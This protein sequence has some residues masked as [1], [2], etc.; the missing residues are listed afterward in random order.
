[1]A[2]DWMIDVISDLRVYALN[3][4]LQ[5]TAGQL[6]EVILVAAMEIASREDRVPDAGERDRWTVG[7]VAGGPAIR[8]V[9]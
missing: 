8:P 6:D 5:A 3:N 4:G 2:N 1:M 7:K 9:A